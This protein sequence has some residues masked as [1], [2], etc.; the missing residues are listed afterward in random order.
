MRLFSRRPPPP[1]AVAELTENDR[2]EQRE[3]A[4][5]EAVQKGHWGAYVNSVA[6]LSDCGTC[7]RVAAGQ[8]G[9]ALYGPYIDLAGGE[10]VLSVTI[11]LLEEQKLGPDE[12]VAIIDIT[13]GSGATIHG[14]SQVYRSHLALTRIIELCFRVASNVTEVE[15]RVA[16][17]G[18]AALSIN[19]R[20]DLRVADGEGEYLPMLPAVSRPLP[21]IFSENVGALRGLHQN[22]CLFDQDDH[23]I[24]LSMHGVRFRLKALEDIQVTN[25][26]F[27][28]HDYAFAM[29]RDVIV[30]DVGMNVGRASLYFASQG[31]VK[32]VHSFEPFPKTFER[33]LGKPS[34]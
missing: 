28:N 27:V 34:A 19:L 3:K 26:V 22:G 20:R 11:D 8:V 32:E 10:Y 15:F 24:V 14:K 33:A 29:P 21:D 13:S 7:V 30:L 5:S 12:V 31:C 18:K 1:K 4:L 2:R 6:S 16:A 17:T 25:E 23:G 9:Y